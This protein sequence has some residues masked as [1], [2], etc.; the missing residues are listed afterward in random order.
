MHS[1]STAFYR[2][3]RLGL[4]FQC[5]LKSILHKDYERIVCKSLYSTMCL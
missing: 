1:R 2:G 4:R 5:I 3:R